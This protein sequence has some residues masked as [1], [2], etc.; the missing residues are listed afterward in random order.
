M[1]IAD[2]KLV[3]SKGERSRQ[4][5]TFRFNFV[6]TLVLAF[7]A[8]EMMFRRIELNFDAHGIDRRWSL[9]G[10]NRTRH[11]DVDSIS[12][13]ESDSNMTAGDTAYYTV[14]AKLDE[15][16]K[17][18]LASALRQRDAEWVVAELKDSL[19]VDER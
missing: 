9:L 4:P 14:Y 17:V 11:L 1:A 2:G 7:G 6:S 15:S 8:V 13:I 5:S 19:K 3:I 10:L 16:K 18:T 12:A